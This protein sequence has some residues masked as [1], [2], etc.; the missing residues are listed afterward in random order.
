[1]DRQL[2]SDLEQKLRL[3]KE[4]WCHLRQQLLW[5][6]F[7]DGEREGSRIRWFYLPNHVYVTIVNVVA[8][9]KYRSPETM[10][11]TY[12][13][14]Y[15]RCANYSNEAPSEEDMV[16]LSNDQVDNEKPPG[17]DAGGADAAGGTK[18]A[19]KGSVAATLDACETYVAPFRFLDHGSLKTVQLR[20][21][22]RQRLAA[23][24]TRNFF[25]G[26][27][28]ETPPVRLVDL[29]AN[30]E[31]M[32]FILTFL[33][34]ALEARVPDVYI[35]NVALDLLGFQPHFRLPTATRVL[36][37]DEQGR[38][39]SLS[40]V[41]MSE[42]TSSEKSVLNEDDIV[43]EQKKLIILEKKQRMEKNCLE[44]ILWKRKKYMQELKQDVNMIFLYFFH[45]E[46]AK[47]NGEKGMKIDGNKFMYWFKALSY[48]A[49]WTLLGTCLAYF[50]IISFDVTWIPVVFLVL[51]HFLIIF[52]QSMVVRLVQNACLLLA[53]GFV[54]H[55]MV[56]FM[57]WALVIVIFTSACMELLGLKTPLAT[58]TL[59]VAVGCIVGA[60][61]TGSLDPIWVGL[62]TIYTLLCT[63]AS[64]RK[65]DWTVLLQKLVTNYVVL[66]LLIGEWSVVTTIC[67]G[68][69]VD[70]V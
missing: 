29:E 7:D 63:I 60:G 3:K 67:S 2:L 51:F 70:V 17:A 66:L 61:I 23:R 22:V 41:A 39:L 33:S 21:N 26:I 28:Q 24:N 58:L 48:A 50:Q 43:Q 18:R 14:L 53:T 64:S 62:Y 4:E 46:R 27:P 5:C 52:R 56:P 32:K 42:N 57:E 47:K 68:G 10:R 65:R 34:H 35:A 8:G 19:D 49:F 40:A 25:V 69:V 13:L 54:L 59:F 31:N 9:D 12:R 38:R 11:K 37:T 30:E 15:W 36:P 44:S 45:S 1:M 6:G 16:Y 55:T 20:H